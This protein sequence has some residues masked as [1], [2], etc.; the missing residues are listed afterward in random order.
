MSLPDDIESVIGQRTFTTK[1]V[2]IIVAVVLAG[3][4]EFFKWQGY[5]NK[6]EQIE[7]RHAS[8]MKDLE[9]ELKAMIAK[10]E[11]ERKTSVTSLWQ[12]YGTLNEHD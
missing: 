4:A 6:V 12:K 7:L 3:A 11:S 8:D 1:Q 5:Q 9:T 10:E 2:I